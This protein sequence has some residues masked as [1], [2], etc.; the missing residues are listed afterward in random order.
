[1]TEKK[2]LTIYTGEILIP[3]PQMER[4]QYYEDEIARLEKI[5]QE[6]HTENIK[7]RDKLDQ[8]RIA[9]LETFLESLT[10][11]CIIFRRD[12]DI[13]MCRDKIAGGECGF[14]DKCIER[15]DLIEKLHLDTGEAP[16]FRN[17]SESSP[18]Y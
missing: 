15:K 18:I 4:L 8:Y 12:L 1:M 17:P 6:G 5:L 9:R 2:E 13:W 10:L 3:R 16:S 14:S 11:K 7:L